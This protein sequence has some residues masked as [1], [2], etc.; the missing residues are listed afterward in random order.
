MMSF[1]SAATKMSA[2]PLYQTSALKSRMQQKSSSSDPPA[3]STQQKSCASSFE[4]PEAIQIAKMEKLGIE[5][6]TSSK[7][8]CIIRKMKIF[9]YA[10]EASYH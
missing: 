3:Q 4:M 8:G 10:K 7:L 6:K 1:E 5:P 2:L 9:E